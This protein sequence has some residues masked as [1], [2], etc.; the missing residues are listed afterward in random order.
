MGVF[1]RELHTL[2]R[3]GISIAAACREV[4]RRS[5]SNLRPVAH[6]MA[7]A[8]EAGQPI[9]DALEA[10]RSL[11]YPWH[12][13]VVR[14][15]EVGGFMPEAFE[16]IAHA[17]EVEWETR[18]TL[19]LRL[20]VYSA[21]GTP[22]ILL[23][24]PLIL[25]VAQPIPPEGWTPQSVIE[26]VV[27]YFRTVSLPIA[28]GLVG[29]L[30]IWQMLQAVVWFQTLQQAIVLRLPLVG[31]VAK[32][33]ALDRYLATL[34]LMLRGGLPIASAAEEA[35][36]AAG[37]PVLT[38]KLL[39]LVPGLREGVPLS[40][41]LAEA[42]IFDPD[43]LNM[44]ATGEVSG[45]L[46]DMLARASGYYREENEAKRRMLLRLAGVVFGVLWLCVFG[47]LIYVG[48][49]TYFDFAFRTYDWM[50]EGFE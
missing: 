46:P 18:S 31:R 30:L 39:D 10:Y 35:A 42:R 21:L 17:Y 20:F 34:G 5:P 38:P 3:T 16:Q 37:S 7:E 43:T 11:F 27:Y 32:T 49:R 2:T 12:L 26:T 14:A 1:F 45:S 22:A 8:A 36:L 24:A 15:S 33:A 28:L 4:E 13:G 40:S 50:M 23:S 19:R 44:A 29:L 47:A 25:T 9:S 6:E 41:L 48:L